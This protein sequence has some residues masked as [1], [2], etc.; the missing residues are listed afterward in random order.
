MIDWFH[1]GKAKVWDDQHNVFLI[2][3]QGNI[4]ASG[5][6]ADNYDEGV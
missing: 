3:T 5:E 6:E 1:N 4:V 2:D